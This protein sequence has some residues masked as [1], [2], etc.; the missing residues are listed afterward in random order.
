MTTFVFALLFLMQIGGPEQTP[1]TALGDRSIIPSIASMPTWYQTMHERL[2]REDSVGA[3]KDVMEL[4]QMYEQHPETRFLVTMLLSDVNFQRTQ[5]DTADIYQPIV[6]TL[7]AHL[8]DSDNKSTRFDAIRV[9]SNLR[10]SPPFEILEPAIKL[11]YWEPYAPAIYTPLIV[12]A[13]FCK[14]S[15]QAIQIA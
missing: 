11:S 2:I 8:F 9:L 14:Q 15:K 1:V 10:P 3:K 4:A 12:A 5:G 7:I 6:P 13:M